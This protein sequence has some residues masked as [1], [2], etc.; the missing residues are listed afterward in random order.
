MPLFSFC[1]YRGPVDCWWTQ[2]LEWCFLSTALPK[3]QLPL[4]MTPVR[5]SPL[6]FHWHSLICECHTQELE[7]LHFVHK[8]LQNGTTQSPSQEAAINNR[9]VCR[10]S[11][12]AYHRMFCVSTVHLKQ[13]GLKGQCYPQRDRVETEHLKK[14]EALFMLGPCLVVHSVRSIQTPHSQWF[15]W[16]SDLDPQL[17][18]G[19]IPGLGEARDKETLYT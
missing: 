14:R 1:F 2:R 3:T 13:W 11:W 7:Q 15:H 8:Y 12:P 10:S 17:L 18:F 16:S 5:H 6:P 4:S 9:L 19:K